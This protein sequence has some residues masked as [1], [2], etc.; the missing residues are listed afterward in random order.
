MNKRAVRTALIG[1]LGFLHLL[2]ATQAQS[3]VSTEAQFNAA[4]AAGR[5]GG[6][7]H[8]VFANDITSTG[9]PLEA[10]S[11]GG[12]WIIDGAGHTYDGANV[13]QGFT[14]YDSDVTFQNITM[15]N[16][17]AVGGIGGRGAALQVNSTN[18][19]VF[20]AGGGGLGGAGGSAEQGVIRPGGAGG[21]GRVAAGGGFSKAWAVALC[22]V[23]A[24][25]SPARC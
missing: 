20:G 8:I 12:V 5:A 24:E 14:V 6:S 11:G 13:N 19:F 23:V 16:T 25:V 21:F 4:V 3:V 2:T 1:G 22:P 15:Q 9:T 18:A 17:R 10:I 7:K